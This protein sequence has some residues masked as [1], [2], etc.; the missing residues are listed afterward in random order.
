M[1]ATAEKRKV[2]DEGWRILLSMVAAIVALGLVTFAD[3]RN[4]A[5]AALE[6]FAAEQ[7]TVARAAAGTFALAL[8]ERG[9]GMTEQEVFRQG[10]KRVRALEQP[11]SVMI[12]L[13]RPQGLVTLDGAIV[14]SPPIEAGLAGGVSAQPWVRLTHPESAALGLPARTSIAGFAKVERQTGDE[15]RLVVLSTARRERDREERGQWR[16]FL[17]FAIGSA[18]VL[19]FGAAALTKQRKELEL[20]RRLALA[21]A[22]HAADERLVRADKLA[23][24]GALATGIAH[25]VATPLGVIVARASRLAPRV[26]E[27]EKSKRAVDAIAEQAHRIGE[28]VRVF[29]SLARG[30]KATLREVAPADIAQ[31]AIG[32]VSHRFE[33]AGVTLTSDVASE[34][35]AISCD[36]ALVE[37]AIVNLLLNALEASAAGGHVSLAVASAA[38]RVS[39]TVDDDGAGISP[40]DAKRAVEPF[41]TTKSPGDGTGLGLAIA[42]E[43][44]AHHNGTLSIGPREGGGTR[45]AIDVPAK[46][47]ENAG[48]NLEPGDAP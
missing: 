4:E 14:K 2:P 19:A 21:E 18:I 47:P 46:P 38:G 28:I 48:T 11:G 29:L 16:V 37:Q 23:T 35:S 12:L 17:S 10:A 26:A 43:I 5:N 20:A 13:A 40:E 3:Q 34:I 24:L 9:P 22:T 6:D 1:T 30:G 7:A 31:I 32:L 39:F 45:A 33:S 44:A 8:D 41:F 27:D 25:Q 42:H 15:I 36:P